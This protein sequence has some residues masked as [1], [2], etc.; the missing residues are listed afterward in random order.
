MSLKH[1]ETTQT[2]LR[3][4]DANKNAIKKYA[5]KER[6]KIKD[7]DDHNRKR[8]TYHTMPYSTSET[9]SDSAGFNV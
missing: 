3:K 9:I 4:A 5:G 7:E 1:G 2:K 6:I 8:R